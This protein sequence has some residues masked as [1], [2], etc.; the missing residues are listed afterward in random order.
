MRR[1]RA[2]L[3]G[4]LTGTSSSRNRPRRRGRLCR[5]GTRSAWCRPGRMRSTRGIS[6]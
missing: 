1:P 6:L 3:Y 2:A 5:T 4:W